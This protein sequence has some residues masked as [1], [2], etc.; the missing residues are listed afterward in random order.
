[1]IT[2]PK[3]YYRYERTVKTASD[4]ALEL[5]ENWEVCCFLRDCAETFEWIKEKK[6]DLAQSD[7][8]HDEWQKEKG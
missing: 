7:S 1:M 2:V 3:K 8:H 5:E 6:L 4:T